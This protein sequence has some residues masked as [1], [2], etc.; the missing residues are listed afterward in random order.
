MTTR[1]NSGDVSRAHSRAARCCTAVVALGVETLLHSCPLPLICQLL[2][3]DLRV[4]PTRA[5]SPAPEASARIDRVRDEVDWVYSRL[6]LPDTCLRRSLT[7]GFRLR[8]HRPRL[9]IGVRKSAGLEAHA[10][11]VTSGTV[12]DWA[13]THG[14]YVP[15]R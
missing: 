15:M 12:I 11:L 13:E 9:V 8:Q 1:V 7:A 4:G 5:A 14:D 6:G 2:R 10:W 3:I